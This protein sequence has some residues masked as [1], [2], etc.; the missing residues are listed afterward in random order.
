[1]DELNSV[2]I[3]F[4][5]HSAIPEF[6]KL[7]KNRQ[8]R[9]MPFY[10]RLVLITL[11]P[12][13][14]RRLVSFVLRKCTREARLAKKVDSLLDKD[15]DGLSM[16][17][18]RLGNWSDSFDK[19]FKLQELDALIA[20]C[21]QHCAFKFEDVDELCQIHEYYYIFNA[22]NYPAGVVPITSV[23]PTEG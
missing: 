5:K 17:Y 4:T 10:T 7:E 6:K 21:Q 12:N 22:V 3:G 1:M 15:H 20:P 16:L 19:K 8:E 9:L 13:I 18:A 2:Y 14:I 23:A 11:V